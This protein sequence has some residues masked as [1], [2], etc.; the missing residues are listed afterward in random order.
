MSEHPEIEAF[1]RAMEE[2]FEVR[3]KLWEEVA[4]LPSKEAF[5]E[6]LRRAKETA[7]RL[8]F[9]DRVSV[10]RRVPVRVSRLPGDAG[11]GPVSE[12]V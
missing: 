1:D 12:A 9:V 4:H 3:R 6:R 2:L 5:L 8:G 10:P 11:S 7:I